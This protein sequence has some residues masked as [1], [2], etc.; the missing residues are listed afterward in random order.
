MPLNILDSTTVNQANDQSINE[1]V[2]QLRELTEFCEFGPFFDDA[3]RDK[4]VIGLHPK[5]EAIQKREIKEAKLTFSKA[6]EIAVAMK[7]A[8]KDTKQVA[9]AL[10]NSAN[11][12]EVKQ[13]VPS[14]SN[15]KDSSKHSK[16]I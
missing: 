3:L 7:T 14:G 12:H 10:G 15:S 13:W 6:I 2:A 9:G 16:P 4:F 11:V 5:N 1:Y 8:A